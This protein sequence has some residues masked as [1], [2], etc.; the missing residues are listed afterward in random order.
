MLSHASCFVAY[1][2]RFPK[3]FPKAALVFWLL[4][5]SLISLAVRA[6][7]LGDT[8]SPDSAVFFFPQ[9]E[10]I[11]DT[12]NAGAINYAFSVYSIQE[13][14]ASKHPMRGF[15]GFTAQGRPIEIFYFP[16]KTDKR[17]LVLGGVHGSELSAIEI[18]KAVVNRLQTDTPYYSVMIIPCLF[19]DNAE[20]ARINMLE[21]GTPANIGRYT[22]P[23]IAD[24]NRQMPPLGKAFEKDKPLDH[25]GRIIETENRLMLDLINDFKPHRLAN[26]HAIRGLQYAGIYADPRTDSKGLAL[27]F[28]SDSSLALEMA[29]YV[30]FRGGFVAGNKP[31]TRPTPVY[32]LDPPPVPKGKFQPRNL[33]GSTSNG[34]RGQ[35]VSLGSWATTAVTDT[36]NIH[37]N[38][39]AIRLIT[40]EFPGA[41]RPTDYDPDDHED[42][43][44]LVDL[45][46]SAIVNVF[47]ENL[48]VEKEE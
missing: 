16:G 36:V 5:F 47:L 2:H 12:A 8:Y 46:A 26:V 28:E 1:R 19:P 40:V 29:R 25:L 39:P 24:P 15:L 42:Y 20:V 30:H 14:M 31:D 37:Y 6:S 48:Y 43:R 13:V 33:Y 38:R 17:A 11:P 23:G 22:A 7:R 35:G 34:N 9:K 18:T 10:Y 3:M 4:A 21:I 27:G 44:T 45:Y 41:K 32:Y